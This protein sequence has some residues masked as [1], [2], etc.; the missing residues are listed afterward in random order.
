M[1]QDI[2]QAVYAKLA[3]IAAVN[4]IVGSAIYP[5]ALPMTHE[6][7]RDGPALTYTVTTNVPGHVLTGSDG[8]STAR[9]QLSAWAQGTNGVAQ[10]ATITSA[11]FNALDGLTEVSNWG[12][13]S[14]EVLSCLKTEEVDLPEPPKAGR[15]EWIRQVASTYEIKYRVPIP[16]HS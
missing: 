16:T 14:T 2:R 6:L 15:D 9:V 7:D 11:L 4:S 12:D 3:S 8:T 1:A 10:V 13:G 5:H